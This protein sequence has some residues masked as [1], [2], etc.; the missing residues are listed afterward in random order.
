MMDH[1]TAIENQ[2][3]ERYLL[4]ELTDA[5]RD[6]YEEHYFECPVCAEDVR[7]GSEFMVYAREV[8]Q[9]HVERPVEGGLHKSPPAT[10]V[11]MAWLRPIAMAAC[12]ILAVGLALG[13]YKS[14]VVHR[15]MKDQVAAQIVAASVVLNPSRSIEESVLPANKVSR[16]RFVIPPGSYKAYRAVI[17][18]TSK[19]EWF[20]RDIKAEETNSAVEWVLTAGA[21]EPGD[22]A[23]VVYGVKDDST[24]DKGKELRLPFRLE[25]QK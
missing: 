13:G 19:K 2:T 22:Y 17:V 16:L 24:L 8:S 25:I 6:D 15:A 5:E 18:D 9:E 12:G 4:G 21:L 11:R 10:V 3:V 20:P 1:N 23:V 14:V 7:Y